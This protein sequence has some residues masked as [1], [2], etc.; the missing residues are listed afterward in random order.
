MNILDTDH[1][2]DEKEETKSFVCRIC[3]GTKCIAVTN[4]IPFNSLGSSVYPAYYMCKKCSVL[5][6][7]PDL[8]S[9]GEVK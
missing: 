7:Y 8:F 5:F 4:V 6:K 1:T 3:G 2:D 9:I